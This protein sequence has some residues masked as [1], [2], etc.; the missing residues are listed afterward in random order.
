[1][2]RLRFLSVAL[3][4]IL[5]GCANLRTVREFA[6]ESAR[7]SAYRDLTERYL[8]TYLREQPYVAGPATELARDNDRRRRE[9]RGDLLELH[10]VLGQ[11]LRTLASLAG[12][13]TL[14]ISKGLDAMGTGLAEH[15][16]LGLDAEHVE[17]CTELAQVAARWLASGRQVRAVRDMLREGDPPLQLLT[18]GMVSLVEHYRAT[19]E[20]E[21]RSVI[22]LLEVELAF[23]EGPQD[24][25]LATLARAQLQVKARE[26]KQAEAIYAEALRGLRTIQAGHR[27]LLERA[28]ELSS[29]ETR[30][31]LERLTRDLQTIRK[32]LEVL[33]AR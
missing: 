10:R 29:S 28:D 33:H 24:R 11:Y 19:H 30:A 20:N 16:E 26:Y 21:Q 18:Q 4:T 25:L 32:N 12:E 1:M 15:P 22:G 31:A 23:L 13:K 7:F 27:Q 14:E 6:S 17:A 2:V 8:D 3:V 5:A 9:A